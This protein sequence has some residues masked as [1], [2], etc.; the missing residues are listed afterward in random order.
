MKKPNGYWTY[1]KCKEAALE[2][3]TKEELRKKYGTAYNLIYKNKWIELAKHFIDIRKINGY[4]TTYEKCK[5]ELAKYKKLAEFKNKWIYKVILNNKWNDLLEDFYTIK[6]GGWSYDECKNIASN[7]SNRTELS[8]NHSA[9]Y[10]KI[11]KNNWN[12][13]LNHMPNAKIWTYDKCVEESLKYEYKYDLKKYSSSAYTS[14]LKNKW[15][16]ILNNMKCKIKNEWTYDE[17]KKYSKKFKTLKDFNKKYPGA[18]DAI[19]RHSWLDI[20]EKLREQKPPNYWTYDKCKDV[21]LKY[22]NLK[23]FRKD[24]GGAYYR[25][26]NNGWS[27]LLEHMKKMPNFYKRA[28]YVYEFSDNTCYVGLT[29]DLN[30]R[31][32]QHLNDDKD[33]I[34]KYI[35]N[36][37]I[38]PNF[39]IK[40]DYLDVKDAVKMEEIILNEY[41]TNNWKALNKNKTGSIGGIILYWTYDK[42]LEEIRKYKTHGDFRKNAPGAYNS[43]YKKGWLYELLENNIKDYVKKSKK[44]L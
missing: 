25:I 21:A 28:L 11:F 1:E 6:I 10:R 22:D 13:L 38:Q 15:Y 18:V 35:K 42:C 16:D 32:Y 30:R 33:S 24:N 19:Y 27:E 17:C 12:E 43:A 31:H 20:I 4:C 29:C 41:K 7:Y 8:K 26:N 14:I 36:T 3:N 23:D 5:T 40:S 44:S 34:Y 39:I 2:C 9:V 37:N